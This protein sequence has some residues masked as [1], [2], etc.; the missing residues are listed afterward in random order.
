MDSLLIFRFLLEGRFIDDES[1]YIAI[2]TAGQ[3][4]CPKALS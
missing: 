4:K 3:P 2:H 1:T